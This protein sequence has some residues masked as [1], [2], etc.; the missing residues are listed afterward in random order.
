VG[1]A[2]FALQHGLEGAFPASAAEH[3]RSRR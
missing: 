2:L 3:V 1:A